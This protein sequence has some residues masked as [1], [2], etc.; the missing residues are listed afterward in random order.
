MKTINN[1]AWLFVLPAILLLAIIGI[2]PLITVINYSLHDVITP[3][4]KA[5]VGFEWYRDILRSTR[6]QESFG[7]SL[8]FSAIIL[9]IEIPLGI[10]IAVSMP[11]KGIWIP[12]CL[13]AISLPLLVPWNIIPVIWRT[14]VH[15][16]WGTLGNVLALFGVTLDWKFNALH[17]WIVIILMDIWHW[18]SLVV[19]LCYSSLT[20]IPY[21]HYQAAAI[22]GASRWK[23]FRYIELPKMKRVLMMAFLLRFMDSFMIYTEPFSINAGGPINATTFLA[24]DLGEEIFAF[25]YG[26]SAAR[27]VIYFFIILFVSWVFQ[28]AMTRQ[29]SDHPKAKS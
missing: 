29:D 18:T 16:E 10:G 12:I 25:N 7:R 5:W 26:P 23:V 2:I 8:T 20:T 17:T 9:M 28:A 11:K 6:F 15:P 24:M 27:S 3:E 1:K 21:A 19:L 4:L 22:D 13:V 14:F